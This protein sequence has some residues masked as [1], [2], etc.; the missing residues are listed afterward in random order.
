MGE[1]GIALA[2]DVWAPYWNPAAQAFAPLADEWTLTKKVPKEGSYTSLT[3]RFQEGFLSK[4]EAWASQ[5]NTLQYFDGENWKDHFTAPLRGNLKIPGVVR[6]FFGTDIGLDS[7]VEKVKAYNGIKTKEDETFAVELKIPWNWVIQS[8]IT[9]LKYEQATEK[10]WVGTQNGLHRFDGAGWKAFNELNNKRINDF[11]I[12]GATV[13]IGTSEGLYRHSR[14]K[15]QRK[16]KVLPKQDITALAFEQKKKELYV[17]IKGAGVARLTPAKEKGSK[18]QWALYQKEADG[19]FDNNPFDIEVDS[20][21][22]WVAHKKG[23][24]H[25][26]RKKWAQLD[27]NG[28]QVRDISISSQSE[29]WFATSNGLILLKPNYALKVGPKSELQKRVAC[30]DP[31]NP[32]CEG[33]PITDLGVWEHHHVGTGLQSNNIIKLAVADQEIWV[34]TGAGIEKMDKAEVQVGI[35]FEKLLPALG[36]NGLYHLNSSF[37]IPAYEWG[38]FGVFLNFVSFGEASVDLGSDDPTSDVKVNSFELVAGLSYGLRISQNFGLGT[39]FKFIYS[40]LISGVAGHAD[41]TTASYAVDLAFLGKDIAVEGFNFGFVIANMG[42]EVWYIDKDKTDP[43]PLMWK[44]GL[45]YD[46]IYTPMHRVV[47]AIDYKKEAITETDAETDPFYLSLAK[48][49]EDP[50]LETAMIN[51]GIEYTY[52]NTISFRTGYLKDNPGQREEMDFGAGVL[53]S[54]L[55]QVNFA[56]IY[57]LSG[58]D[59]RNGQTRFDLITKF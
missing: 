17:G 53:L 46:V 56:M 30:A 5:D 21:H 22:V 55:I 8:P 44:I 13:W 59:V 45:S 3:T 15:L 49:W 27:F 19:L 18:D 29:I 25:F 35:F 23:V 12:Q 26:D 43:I 10:L 4:S 41:A 39:A 34:S 51:T 6:R 24:S 40:D 52:N 9:T 14:G 58:N 16:G 11:A 48:T 42:P 31:T 32:S 54:D 50:S 47:L 1:T 38:T 57:D 20:N 28:S 7:L 33:S 37:T 2:E 36:I